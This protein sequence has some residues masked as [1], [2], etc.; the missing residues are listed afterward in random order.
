VLPTM[1]TQYDRQPDD[2]VLLT[3]LARLWLAGIDVDW[4]AFYTREQRRRI[5]LPTYPF[6]RQRFWI[7][8]NRQ[9]KN[10]RDRKP[11]GPVRREPDITDWFHVPVWKQSKPLLSRRA[12][13]PDP[14]A[15]GWLVFVDDLPLCGKVVRELRARGERV[16]TVSSGV[17]FGCTDGAYTIDPSS[18]DDYNRLLDDLSLEESL[19][20][21]VVHLWNLASPGQHA[22][23][24]ERVE[25]LM[26]RG[27]Y[28]LLYLTQSLGARDLERVR[29]LVVASGMLKVTGEEPLIPENATLTGPCRII[30]QEYA[31][32]GCRGI[33]VVLPPTDSAQEEN[34][35]DRIILE[36]TQDSADSL[37][38]YRG[39]QRWVQ[40]FEPLRF[41]PVP[42][43]P[44]TL[45]QGGVYLITGGLGGIGLAIA[46]HL[47]RTVEAKLVL[48]G[49]SGLPP[50]DEWDQFLQPAQD[51]EPTADRQETADKVWQVLAIE[52]MGSE[53]LVLSADVADP[54]QMRDVIRRTLDRFGQLNGVFH[55][56]GV[57]GQGLM[58][59]RTLDTARSI[60][61]P[62]VAGLV[63][64]DEALRDVP[65]DFLLLISSMT[66]ITGGGP[67][68]LEYCSGNAYMDAYAHAESSLKRPIISVDWG[69]WRWNAWETGLEGF[70]P[71]ERERLRANRREYG[72][73]FEEGMDALN[74]ALEYG[75]PQ[76][77]VSTQ[78]FQ[79]H[80]DGRRN[81]TVSNLL[82]EAGTRCGSQPC[83]SRPLPG[84]PS[85]AP[86]NEREGKLVE[87]W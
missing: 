7:E 51:D 1:R 10:G 85:A 52:E 5:P 54:S 21:R 27:F 12:S 39:G 64:L 17:A 65:I 6:E 50:R 23:R 19:P 86:T 9:S 82:Q 48:V 77:V 62:K 60:L 36:I 68:Q 49:R 2:L 34:L 75:L 42:E 76:V 16:T 67:G 81:H 56:A 70:D 43:P 30:D 13:S 83:G 44:A 80:I 58:Q 8:T 26:G 84:T 15:G 73:A 35:V 66:A 4:N 24:A 47:A 41:E 78:D 3:T 72:I 45:R 31:A 69:E 87:I 20:A 32:I 33:D 37:V 53:V 11:S 40:H 14:S 28:S 74:R 25:T 29:I 57:P 71:E 22:S 59:L 55:G 79:T 61:A 38:A 46:E 18:R 63:S